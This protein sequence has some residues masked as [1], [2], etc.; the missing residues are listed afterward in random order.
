MMPFDNF[1]KTVGGLTLLI[2]IL[3]LFFSYQNFFIGLIL[4]ILGLI[5]Y[6]K[7]TIKTEYLPITNILYSAITFFAVFIF[8][9]PVSFGIVYVLKTVFTFKGISTW[10]VFYYVTIFLCICSALFNYW[11]HRK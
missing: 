6:L 5:G 8:S 1:L 7:K 2:G 3:S 11:Q 4:F 9:L 10:S